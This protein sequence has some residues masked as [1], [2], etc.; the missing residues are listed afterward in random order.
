MK[1]NSNYN[2]Q[3]DVILGSDDNTLYLWEPADKKQPLLRLTG[4]GKPV[5]LVQF[6]PGMSPITP[7]Q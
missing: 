1:T 6:S 2:T 5:T 4:H 3:I 7:M